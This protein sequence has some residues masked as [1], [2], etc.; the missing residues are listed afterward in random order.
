MGDY[1]LCLRREDRLLRAVL[2][3]VE[4]EALKPRTLARLDKHTFKAQTY[5]ERRLKLQRSFDS[6]LFDLAREANVTR[7]T[8]HLGCHGAH[9]IRKLRHEQLLITARAGIILLVEL[10]LLYSMAAVSQ[11]GVIFIVGGTTCQ[12]E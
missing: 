4:L 10:T 8:D 7:K 9:G 3:K 2:F 5:A 6:A 1:G 12:Q 11:S